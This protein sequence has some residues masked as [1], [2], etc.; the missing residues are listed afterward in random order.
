MPQLAFSTFLPEYAA[1]ALSA[2][3]CGSGRLMALDV[4][5]ALLGSWLYTSTPGRSAKLT[6]LG[7]CGSAGAAVAGVPGSQHRRS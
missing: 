5:V 2:G 6:I 7:L 3:L 4:D 1:V